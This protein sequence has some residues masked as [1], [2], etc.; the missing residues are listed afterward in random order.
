[1]KEIQVINLEERK[2]RWDYTQKL[3]SDFNI[4]RF[5]AIKKSPGWKGCTLSHL[6]IIENAK[7][8]NDN[9]VVVMED[10]VALYEPF[11]FKEKYEKIISY[12]EE[13]IDKWDIFQFGTTNSHL[14]HNNVSWVDKEL[15]IIEYQ[16][17]YAASFI[18]YNSSVFDKM[19]TGKNNLKNEKNDTNDVLMNNFGFRMWTTIPFLAFQKDGY[20]NILNTKVTY[21]Y[22]FDNNEKYLKNKINK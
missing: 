21:K 18:I 10:D 7:K 3:F 12:L 6:T 17:G 16:F 20:S 19:I 5:N 15:N 11:Y 2:D 1:M 14:R 8:N 22:S 13:N 9:Y 4:K